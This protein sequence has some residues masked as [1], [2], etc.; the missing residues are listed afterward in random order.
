MKGLLG[1]LKK[2]RTDYSAIKSHVLGE[3]AEYAEQDDFGSEEVSSANYD[4]QFGRGKF[5]KEAAVQGRSVGFGNEYNPE[6]EASLDPVQPLELPS[7]Q[8]QVNTNN[9]EVM[10]RLAFIENQLTA[11]KSQVELVNERLKNIDAKIGTR[12]Y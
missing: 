6:F 11:I 10:D 1:F 8:S 2:H 5:A 4:K 7:S 9:Y 3:R 12:R